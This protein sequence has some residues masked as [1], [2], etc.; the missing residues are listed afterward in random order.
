MAYW[1][2][3]LTVG[4]ILTSAVFAQTRPPA[5]IRAHTPRVH[6]FV[7]AKVILGP[8][9][10]IEQAT[11]VVR[12]GVIEAVGEQVRPPADARVWNMKG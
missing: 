10:V 3:T 7:N 6:A 8:G 9:N 1:K 2:M 11:L 12:D 5:G 4:I